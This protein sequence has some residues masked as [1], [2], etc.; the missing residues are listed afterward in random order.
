MEMPEDSHLQVK[1]RGLHRERFAYVV[2]M[3]LR[4]S[5]VWGNV[6][7]LFMLKVYIQGYEALPN[8]GRG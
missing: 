5:E 6:L 1:D 7:L 2:I 4:S 8:D 3:D